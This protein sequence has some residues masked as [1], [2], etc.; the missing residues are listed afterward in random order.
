MIDYSKLTAWPFIEARKILKKIKY[1]IPEKGYVLFETGYG[2][3]GL[4]HIGT[5]GE[6]TRTAMVINAMKI[7]VPEIPTRLFA[8]SDDLDGLRKAP[9]NIPNREM[10]IENIGRPLSSVPDPFCEFESY[11]AYMNNRLQTFLDDFGFKYEFQSSTEHYKSGKYNDMMHSVALNCEKILDIMKPSLNEER[12]TTYHPI[13][14]ICQKTGK[15]IF[16]GVISCNPDDDTITFKDEFCEEQTISILDG[17]CKLQWKADWAMRW[18]KLGV[19]YEMFGKDIQPSADLSTRICQVLGGEPPIQ[20]RYEMF[21]DETGKKIS[22]SKGNGVSVTDWLKYGTVESL[23]LFM[24][25]KPETSKRLYLSMIPKQVDEYIK[26]AKEFREGE[27][28]SEEEQI[29]NMNSPIFHLPLKRRRISMDFRID[30]SLIMNLASV[31]NPENSKVLLNYIQRYQAEL[32]ND[33][34]EM[35]NELV[36]KALNFYNDFIKPCKKFPIINENDREKLQLLYDTYQQIDKNADEN[37]LQQVIYDV[38][39]K[40]GYE[41]STIR[42]WFKFLYEHL[43]GSE[44]GPRFGSFVKIYGMENF[45]T[46]INKRIEKNQKTC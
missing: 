9:E 36:E 19:D 45:L 18:V 28:L 17:N 40:F 37:S 32:T 11:A 2:P 13:L 1:K 34:S 31:C 10:V 33:E 39:K 46:L 25:Q 16:D 41:K 44:F 42:D 20:Y 26:L 23:L 24:Y 27:E 43:F 6:V 14:P 22:K 12:R 21:T 30:F 35:V 4:P 8:Y 38:G 3:S 5:F 29:N 7:L 15:F